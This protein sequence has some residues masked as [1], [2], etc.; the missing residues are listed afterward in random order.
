MCCVSREE[1]IMSKRIEDFDSLRDTLQ[2]AIQAKHGK[3]AWLDDFSTEEAIF[4]KPKGG[5][6]KE[7][8]EE[9]RA[10]SVPY[11]VENGGI[12]F[13]GAHKEVKR[14]S[15]WERV[16][17]QAVDREE[18]HAAKAKGA[19]KAKPAEGQEESFYEA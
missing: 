3:R 12:K 10:Y 13:T 16:K 7:G 15:G 14:V 18:A 17:K 2:K 5:E 1:L 11:S 4:H 19:K 6:G 8:P 9:S